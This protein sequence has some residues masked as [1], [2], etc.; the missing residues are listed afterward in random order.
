M[1][2]NENEKYC[3]ALSHPQKRIWYNEQLFPETAIHHICGIGEIRGNINVSHLIKS[4]QSV[5]QNHQAFQF[6]MSRRQEEPVQTLSFPNVFNLNFMNFTIY[7]DPL[8][9]YNKWLQTQL[10]KPLLLHGFPS[11]FFEVFKISDDHYGIFAKLHHLFFDGWSMQLLTEEISRAYENVTLDHLPLYTNFIDRETKYLTSKRAEKDRLYWNHKFKNIPDPIFHVKPGELQAKRKSYSINKNLTSS[12]HEWI[13][14]YNCSI[15]DFF[16]LLITI[17]I[18]KVYGMQSFTLAAPVYNRTTSHEK[19]TIGMFT[20]TLPLL[21]TIDPNYSV[22]EMLSLVKKEIRQTYLHQKYPYDLLIQDL[23][24]KKRGYDSLFQL[25]V[26]YYPFSPVS[27]LSDNPFTLIEMHPGEQA[28]PMQL[29]IK[30]WEKGQLSIEIDYQTSVFTEDDVQSMFCRLIETANTVIHNSEEKIRNIGILTPGEKLRLLS[31][32]NQTKREYPHDKTVIHL[33]E[34]QVQKAPE[35]TAISDGPVQLSYGELYEQMNRISHSLIS[36]GVR[37]GDKVGLHG[38]HSIDL[39]A[40]ILAILKIG[41]AYVPLEHT[42]PAKRLADII[43]DS[44]LNHVLTNQTLPAEVDYKGEVLQLQKMDDEPGPNLFNVG[45]SS[46]P[47]E[48]AYMIYTSGSTGKPKGVRVSHKNLTNYCWWANKKYVQDETEVFALYS[49]L[50]FDLTLTSLFVPLIGGHEIQ[51]YKESEEDFVLFQILRENKVSVLKL[52]PSHLSLIKDSGYE[53][54]SLQTLIVGGENLKSVTARTVQN[55][56]NQ[57]IKIFNEYGPTEATVGCMIHHFDPAKDTGVSVP[58]GKPADNVQLYVLDEQ[59]QPVPEGSTGEL[60]IAG[61]GLA[62][63]YWR[64]PDITDSHFIPNPF[65]HGKRMY[66][67]G[68]L[69]RFMENGL[70]EY[71]GRKDHQV[72]INGFRIELEEVEARLLDVKEIDYVHVLDRTLKDGRKQ[73]CAYVVLNEEMDTSALKKILSHSLPAYMIPV[74][75]IALDQ[76]PLTTNGKVDRSKLPEPVS[77]LVVSEGMIQM[78]E[79]EQILVDALR[80]V[81]RVDTIELIHDFYEWGGDSIKAIQLSSRLKQRGYSLKTKDILANPQIGQM[82][83]CMK[84]N[85]QRNM[86]DQPVEGEVGMS[87]IHSWFFDQHFSQPDYYHQSILLELSDWMGD[88]D[89]ESAFQELVRQHDSLRMNVRNNTVLFYNPIHLEKDFQLNVFDLSAMEYAEQMIAIA[90]MGRHLKSDFDLE[91]GLLIKGA[92]FDLGTQGKRL[93]VIVHHLVI[94]GVSW[95]ILLED[96]ALILS[97]KQHGNDNHQL[98]KTTSYRNWVEKVNE[99]AQEMPSKHTQHWGL[100][101]EQFLRKTRFDSPHSPVLMRDTLTS[102]KAMGRGL[103]KKWLLDANTAYQTESVDLLIASLAMALLDMSKDRCIVMQLEG[104]G[105]EEFNEE[106]DISRTVGWFTSIYPVMFELPDNSLGEQIKY[107]KE[108]LRT[109]P[110]KGF[111]YLINRYLNNKN[112]AAGKWEHQTVRFNYLGDFEGLEVPGLFTLADE[113]IGLDTGPE[114]HLNV[115]LDVSVWI[116]KGEVHFSVTYGCSVYTEE[117]ITGL[118]NLWSEKFIQII[119]HCTSKES[120]EYTPSDFETVGLDQEELDFLLMD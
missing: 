114:N 38:P 101:E 52:T 83:S 111:D 54:T 17:Y 75:F 3:Y 70:L 16:M 55:Q 120:T 64:R 113:T 100:L 44:G 93:L 45:M 110:N 30:E 79:A 94:D 99:Y 18:Y 107:I 115:Q 86:D 85:Q 66:K 4:I 82:A 90:E 49:S 57:E 32:F 78:S 42:Y 109:V 56:F 29:I 88:H 84:N 31:E 58:I 2:P 21:F 12:I 40:G 96:F 74:H 43:F 48:T 63:G 23:Q 15:N 34:E 8:G 10:K 67:T 6:N 97:G 89:L 98:A 62:S 106:I 60:Y 5:I 118:L 119:E 33:F 112:I 37:K 71:I 91:S 105:R 47:A 73:L 50:S 20:S 87:P 25:A 51:I 104:H 68:D 77:P 46:E 28:L 7:S 81:L 35:K 69:V 61:D 95:R 72:K 11:Y 59:Q 14:N 65:Q 117:Q 103:T 22:L 108:Q 80:D 53:N 26:N 19:K 27:L 24:L 9:E 1:I 76:I 92:C 41:A 13:N 36:S 102:H 39:V 116:L